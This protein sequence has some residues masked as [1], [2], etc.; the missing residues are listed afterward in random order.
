MR[1]AENNDVVHF[2]ASFQLLSA[3]SLERP[4]HW[5]EPGTEYEIV[6][7]IWNGSYTAPVAGLPVSFSFLSFGIGASVHAIATT[8]VDLG[9][10]G[11]SSCPAF[12]RCLWKTPDAGGHYCLQVE[13]RWFDDANP[14]NNLGQHNTDVKVLNSPKASFDL[15]VFNA[16]QTPSRIRLRADSY[17]LLELPVC[18]ERPQSGETLAQRVLSLKSR[19]GYE[20]QRTPPES[21]PL[22]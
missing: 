19:H 15:R 22:S 5:L 14:A 10:K 4:S 9:V 16:V 18:G 6:A 21:M 2:V 20:A 17:A 3:L 8:F 13:L 7:R 1:V 11:S 12:A